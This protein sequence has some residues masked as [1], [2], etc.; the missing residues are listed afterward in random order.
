MKVGIEVMVLVVEIVAARAAAKRVVVVITDSVMTAGIRRSSTLMKP[1]AT[2]VLPMTMVLTAEAAQ[3][4]VTMADAHTAV[5]KDLKLARMSGHPA[6]VAMNFEVPAVITAMAPAAGLQAVTM[7]AGTGPEGEVAH[8]CR[9]PATVKTEVKAATLQG[10]TA[11]AVKIAEIVTSRQR[12]EVGIPDVGKAFG[13]LAMPS[14]NA[15]Y[16]AGPGLQLS[17]SRLCA[18]S[19]LTLTKPNLLVT[20][21]ALIAKTL[22]GVRHRARNNKVEEACSRVLWHVLWD[23]LQ[24]S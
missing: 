12:A 10:V 18:A 7:V 2:A 21:Q 13:S 22:H 9:L 6:K 15:E 20:L 11:A 5:D 24:K 1:A 23:V 14:R 16:P 8:I 4:M 17:A 19:A 3:G